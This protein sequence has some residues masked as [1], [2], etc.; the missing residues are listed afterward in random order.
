[1]ESMARIG[2]S[3]L[4]RPARPAL[5]LL[6]AIPSLLALASTAAAP[7]LAA[8]LTCTFLDVGQGDAV[9]LVGHDGTTMLVDAGNDHLAAGTRVERYLKA[10]GIRR[11]DSVVVTHAHQDHFGG[12]FHLI[13]RVPIGRVLYGTRVHTDNYEALEA[14]IRKHG[15]EYRHVSL[16]D[17]LPL[18][19]G[20]EATVLHS[21][22]EELPP[23]TRILDEGACG[24]PEAPPDA[25]SPE[26]VDLNSLSVVIRVRYGCRSLLLMGDA[27]ASVEEALVAA[28]GRR[29]DSDV[30]KVSHHGSRYSSTSG[31]LREVDPEYAAIC[32]GRQNDYGHPTVEAM[33]RLRDAGARLFR[34]DQIGHIEARTDGRTLDVRPANG[35]AVPARDRIEARYRA[36][37]LM[38]GAAGSAAGP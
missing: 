23:G 22:R 15:I 33:A 16:G 6:L 10:A 37:G 38:A 5:A 27:T 18:G 31:F 11:L 12:L 17:R 3:R 29:L 28:E 19:P 20:A 13:G 24:R 1:M 34:T 4:S 25:E 21:G 26:G 35:A 32:V 36:F 7:V 8:G 2:F 9:L 30:L 14:R